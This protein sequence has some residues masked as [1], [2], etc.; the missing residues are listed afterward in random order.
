MQAMKHLNLLHNPASVSWKAQRRWIIE[1]IVVYT[2]PDV[3]YG[4][5]LPGGLP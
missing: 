5:W 2:E 3:L 4:P 1:G